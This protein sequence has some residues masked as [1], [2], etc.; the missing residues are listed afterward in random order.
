MNSKSEVVMAMLANRFESTLEYAMSFLATIAMTV[1]VADK[2]D[3]QTFDETLLEIVPDHGPRERR[4]TGGFAQRCKGFCQI[5]TRIKADHLTIKI[6]PPIR[7]ALSGTFHYRS[8][9]AG[10]K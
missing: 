1:A 4:G 10:I 6:I 7:Q 5:T 8:Q 9:H 2:A 3:A